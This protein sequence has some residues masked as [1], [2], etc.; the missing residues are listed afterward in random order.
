MSG[1]IPCLGSPKRRP[2]YDI[3][4]RRLLIRPMRLLVR[5]LAVHTGSRGAWAPS[6]ELQMEG[7]FSSRV[8]RRLGRGP[9]SLRACLLHECAI[10]HARPLGYAARDPRGHSCSSGSPGRRTAGIGATAFFVSQSGSDHAISPRFF[11]RNAAKVPFIGTLRCLVPESS[12]KCPPP[13]SSSKPP[14][15]SSKSP[16]FS[17]PRRRAAQ[18]RPSTCS[19]PESG[20]RTPRRWRRLSRRSRIGGL[21]SGMAMRL[22]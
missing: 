9:Y 11:S 17:L 2:R 3:A 1:G 14:G 10:A 4:H 19:S 13:D 21:Y 8:C 15:C 7:G 12:V 5:P 6:S 16:R 22:R 20:Y 18:R